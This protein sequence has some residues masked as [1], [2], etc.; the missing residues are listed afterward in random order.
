MSVVDRRG[1]NAASDSLLQE[2]AGDLGENLLGAA[3]RWRYWDRGG[4]PEDAWRQPDFDDRA[5]KSGPAP[6]GYERG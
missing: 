5:W 2:G 3:A 6:L 4:L 1:L